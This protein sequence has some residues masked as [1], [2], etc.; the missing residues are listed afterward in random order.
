MDRFSSI[1]Q[2]LILHPRPGSFTAEGD[3]ARWS[4]KDLD[5]VPPEEKKWEWYH[6]GAFWVAEGFNVAQLETPSSAIALGLNPGLAITACFVGNMLVMI[7]TFSSAYVGSKFGLN[8]PVISRASFGM[9]GAYIAMVIRGVV[10][11]IWMGV[12]SSV[13]GNAVRC[14]IQAIWPSFKHWHA[15]A[16]PVSAAITAPDLLSFAVFWILQLPFMF[17]SVNALRWMLMIKVAVM[18]FF[19]VC[20]FTWALT[21]SNGWGPLFSIPTKVSNGWTVGYVFCSTITAAISSNATFAVNMGDMTRYA[22]NRHHA[23]QMQ[24]ALPV[25]MTLTELLGTVMAASAQVVYGQILWNPLSVV[26]LWTNR[27]A[28]FSA[29]LLFCFANI[30]TNVVGNSVPFANDLM[31]MVPK[32]INLR[33]GQIICAIL[34]FAICPW[35]IQAKAQRFLGFLN[36]YTVFLGPLIGLLVSDYWLVRKGQ[37]YNVRA[38]Y[39]P[40][41]SLYWY[42]AGFN[43]RAIAAMLVGIVPLVPGLAHSINSNLAISRGAQAYYTMAWL[44]GLVLTALSYYILFLISPWT[45]ESNSIIEGRDDVEAVPVEMEDSEEK[46]TKQS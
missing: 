9:R 1:R 8:F 12:Q 23:W 29:G 14:M 31:G 35:L 22:H 10:C 11:V 44:D 25:V 38:L 26:L 3:S 33:R 5:P 34:G 24:F 7:P 21:A 17:L 4:N 16:L 27:P 43:W 18:P 30:M 2:R 28:Q 6:V 37:G 13:G 40:G 15:D 36:G 42:T 32:Y 19:G 20:L 46:Y 39:Q 41:N 45:L